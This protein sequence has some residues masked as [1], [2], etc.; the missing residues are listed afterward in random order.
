[1]PIYELT[2]D[3]LIKVDE[4]SLASQGIRERDDLQRI[5]RTQISAV[6]PDSYVL[7][8]EFGEWEDSRRSIDLLC[9]DKEANLVVV[10][11]KRTEDGGH[12]ELQAIRYAAMISKMTFADAVSAHRKFLSKIGRESDEAEGEILKFLEWDEPHPGEFG[13]DVRIVLVSNDF[14]KEI[15]TSVM[16]LNDYE[17]DIRKRRLATKRSLIVLRIESLIAG[18]SAL[19]PGTNQEARAVN[20]G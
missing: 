15:T 4:A 8:E 16:W 5:L 17:I 6:F 9:I 7:A 11:L 1:M 14:K 19:V 20:T 13:K 12:M 2:R 18:M 10:E 3:S